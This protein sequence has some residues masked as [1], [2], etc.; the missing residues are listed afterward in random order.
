MNQVGHRPGSQLSRFILTHEQ[1]NRQF[2]PACNW[3]LHQAQ[4]NG[5]GSPQR[6]VHERAAVACA[7]RGLDLGVS[8]PRV[9]WIH[10]L[11][12]GFWGLEV[13]L[14]YLMTQGAAESGHLDRSDL[15]ALRPCYPSHWL[16]NGAAGELGLFTVFRRMWME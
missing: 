5:Y 4:G 2:L 8:G 11:P 16:L 3:V 1:I 6:E 7:F 10:R 14:T 13:E 15:K 12:S 9:Q